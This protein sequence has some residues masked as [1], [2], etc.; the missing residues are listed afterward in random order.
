MN[1]SDM[2]MSDNGWRQVDVEN[3]VPRNGESEVAGRSAV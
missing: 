3:R 1:I 2:K